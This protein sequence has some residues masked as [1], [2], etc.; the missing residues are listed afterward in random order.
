MIFTVGFV[1]Q[2]GLGACVELLYTVGL[3]ASTAHRVSMLV[4]GLAILTL[5][6]NWRRR[7]GGVRASAEGPC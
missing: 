1:V 3:P 7:H 5:G 4:I 6:A 2:A